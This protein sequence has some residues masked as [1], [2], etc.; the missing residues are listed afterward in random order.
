MIGKINYIAI[1]VTFSLVTV[2]CNIYFKPTPK[3]LESYKPNSDYNFY[4]YYSAEFEGQIGNNYNHMIHFGL[5]YSDSSY[6]IRITNS[7]TLHPSEDFFSGK[8]SVNERGTVFL[9]GDSPFL[10][11]KYQIVTSKRSVQSPFLAEYNLTEKYSNIFGNKK[12]RAYCEI[13]FPYKLEQCLL[14][15]YP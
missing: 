2:G 9:N 15:K 4:K 10:N 7:D 5:N 8:Y 14:N 13:D 12:K 6:W 1:L 3:K 11:N